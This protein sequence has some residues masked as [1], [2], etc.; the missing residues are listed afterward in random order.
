M[1]PLE[2]SLFG[3]TRTPAISRHDAVRALARVAALTA[4]GMTTGDALAASAR[5]KA[6]SGSDACLARLAVAVRRGHS[7]STAM[8]G[9]GLPFSEA[10][11]AVVRA[12]EA[13]GATAR[14][15]TLLAQR[16]EHD[17]AGLR[18]IASALTYPCILM[19]GALASLSFLSIVV[20]PSFTSLYAGHKAQLPATTRGLLAFGDAAARYGLYVVLAAGT[21]IAAAGLARSQSL[22][23]RRLCAR[24][25]IAVPLLR[26]L[27]AP[28]A[29][30]ASC[31]LLALL[32]AAGCE[33]EEAL[34]LAARAS[35]N[36]IVAE[37]LTRCLR[38]LRRGV[39]LSQAWVSA[40]LDRSGDAV[41]L[42]EIAEAT[43]NYADAFSKLGLLEGQAADE[44]VTRLCRLAEPVSV[45]VMACAVGGGV[46]ALYQPMLGSA[47][48]LLGGSQ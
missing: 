13:G 6:R 31:G 47:S 18:R 45:V 38:L 46:L 7:L 17:S 44:A 9:P 42:L 37:R 4:A 28:S 26:A 21:M 8:A 20:L 5:R 39:P 15:L 3:R 30:H 33:A 35:V 27:F 32:F 29:M 14:T 48:L 40:D 24:A 12:G 16:I 34:A 41:A 1:N 36:V 11:I 22:R 2:L 23:W 43:G 19:V 25:A 10:E